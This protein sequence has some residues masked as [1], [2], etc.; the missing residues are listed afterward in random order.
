MLGLKQ[1][2]VSE[3]GPLM[4]IIGFTKPVPTHLVKSLQLIWK[5]G[6]VDFIYR[7]Q[8]SNE[9]PPLSIIIIIH[10]YNDYQILESVMKLAR[11]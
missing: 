11:V 10:V 3:K 9:L 6:A 4:A 8:S 1:I 5:L 2:N 7:Y